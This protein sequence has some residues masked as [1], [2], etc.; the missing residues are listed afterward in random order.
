MLKETLN[1]LS[2]LPI[3]NDTTKSISYEEAIK[4]SMQPQI[5]GNKTLLSCVR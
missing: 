3:E 1:Y 5:V 4:D 2:I